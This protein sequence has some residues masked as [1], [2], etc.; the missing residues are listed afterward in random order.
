MEARARTASPTRH[1][2]DYSCQALAKS[3]Y[4]RL[5]KWIVTRINGALETHGRSAANFIGCLDIAGF[6]IF[7]VTPGLFARTRWGRV[8]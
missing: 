4:E 3:I 8:R 2:A 6:E 1:Q 5:F 7:E